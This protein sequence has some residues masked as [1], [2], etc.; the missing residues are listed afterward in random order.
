MRVSS[1]VHDP[2]WLPPN[3]KNMAFGEPLWQIWYFNQKSKPKSFLWSVNK[4]KAL[5]MWHDSH[6][7]IAVLDSTKCHL[8]LVHFCCISVHS[9]SKIV[10]I[11]CA[12][13]EETEQPIHPNC[14][15][16]SLKGRHETFHWSYRI[17]EVISKTSQTKQM[18]WLVWL[19]LSRKSHGI[20]CHTL[21]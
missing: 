3:K 7:I 9:E 10:T 6:L 11:V 17:P 5:V 20:I 15:I 18:L 2:W 8:D 21:T 13:S 12:T 1:C 19:F 16:R 4:L 14:R